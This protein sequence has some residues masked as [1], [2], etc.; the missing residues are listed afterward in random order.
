[1]KTLSSIV[2]FTILTIVDN[3][4]NFKTSA[5]IDVPTNVAVQ[6]IYKFPKSPDNKAGV[7][8]VQQDS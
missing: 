8:N 3:Q 2:G 1:M 4:F 5:I 6:Y 7:K